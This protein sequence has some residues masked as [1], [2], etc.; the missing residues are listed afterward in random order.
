MKATN[1]HEAKLLA[2]APALCARAIGQPISVRDTVRFPRGNS[3]VKG[4]VVSA[5]PAGFRY[6]NASVIMQFRVTVE[7]GANKTRHTF[8]IS[9]LPQS[10]SL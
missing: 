5:E 2:R 6:T 8:I 1:P 9:R 10:P 7:A 3:V 4:V